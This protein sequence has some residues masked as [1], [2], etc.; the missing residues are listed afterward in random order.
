MSNISVLARILAKRKV[1]RKCDLLVK[2][3]G[4]HHVSEKHF[5]RFLAGSPFCPSFLESASESIIGSSW[6]RSSE[7]SDIV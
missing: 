2:V 6:V 5:L 3:I 1:I 4:I 7:N